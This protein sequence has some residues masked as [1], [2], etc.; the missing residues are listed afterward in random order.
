[1]ANTFTVTRD[2]IIIAAL[3]KCAVISQ[4]DLPEPEQVVEAAQALEGLIKHLQASTELRWNIVQ[5]TQAL[6]A[7]TRSIA[8]TGSSDIIDL[9][10][11]FIRTADGLDSPIRLVDSNFFDQAFSDKSIEISNPTVAMAQFDRSTL[12]VASVALTFYPITPVDCTLYYRA[13]V[14]QANAGNGTDTQIFDELWTDVLIYGLASRLADE[15][16]LP[17]ER[18]GYLDGKYQRLLDEAQRKSHA[19][20]DTFFVYPV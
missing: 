11:C 9:F 4:G 19:T 18:C 12:N 6:P 14:K 5:R 7:S 3:R 10:N 17:I 2:N 15:Y 8:L 13:L 20:K 1:M 16:A